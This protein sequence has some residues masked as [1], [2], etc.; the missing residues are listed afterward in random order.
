MATQVSVSVGAHVTVEHG[1]H[2]ASA[3][4]VAAT[5]SREAPFIWIPQVV[6]AAQFELS[7]TA[8]QNPAAHEVQVQ[9]AV[10]VAA[11]TR[12]RVMAPEPPVVPEQEV[13][14]T[15][16]SATALEA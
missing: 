8:A 7:L 1:L 9:S 4:A 14:A 15:Q 2:I 3:V 12:T 13:I 16:A 5:E 10:A 6:M 11:L